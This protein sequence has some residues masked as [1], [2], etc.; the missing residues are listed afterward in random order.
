MD[1]PINKNLEWKAFHGFTNEDAVSI[2]QRCNQLPNLQLLQGD[3]NIQKQATLPVEW[4]ADA[5]DA[6]P[7][8]AA[9]FAR[10]TNGD[11]RFEICN[12]QQLQAIV[13]LGVGEGNK[14]TLSADEG[15]NYMNL[16]SY[17]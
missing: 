11:G 7:M 16:T 6:A 13:T 3:I 12:I 2:N 17:I 4:L 10:D 8:D 14:T 5:F 15:Y 9:E 1:V